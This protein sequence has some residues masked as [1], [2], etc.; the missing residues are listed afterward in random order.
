MVSG[1]RLFQGAIETRLRSMTP[2]RTC[3]IV[4]ASWPSCAEW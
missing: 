2:E 4:S 3:S 1:T